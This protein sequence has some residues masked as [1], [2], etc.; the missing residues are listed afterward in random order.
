MKKYLARPSEL[1][2]QTSSI[3]ITLVG[4]LFL[5]IINRFILDIPA[6]PF[7]LLMLVAYATF[8]GGIKIGFISFGLALIY[9]LFYLSDN[10]W[11]LSYS[12][13]NLLR[14]VIFL[15][16]TPLLVLMLGLMRQ[17][18][19]RRTEALQESEMNYRLLFENSLDGIM[20][21]IPDGR[22][23]KANP[24]L[25]RML[26]YEEAEI[27]ALGR[28]GIVDMSDPRAA[29][30]LE[31]R[32]RTGSG[33]GKLN[34]L[35]KDGSKIPCLVTSQVFQDKNG[36]PRTSVV[37][38]DLRLYRKMEQAL[39]ESEKRY[40][41][42]AHH[43][44]DAAVLLFDHDLRYVLA[45]GQALGYDK[46]SVEGK[47]I[48][49]VLPS[50]RSEKLASFYRAALRGETVSTEWQ[51][52]SGQIYHVQFLPLR[53]EQGEITGGMVFSQDITR[54]KQMEQTLQESEERYRSIVTTLHEGIVIQNVDGEIVTCNASAE[55]ILGLNANQMMDRT[56]VD[57]RWRAVHEDG[58]PFPGEEHPAMV[59]LRTG[60]PCYDVV[61][62]MHKPEGALTWILV[63]SQ[64]IQLPGETK[65]S[66]VITSFADITQLKQAE[67]LLAAEKERLAVTLQSI[68]DAVI[69]TD[70]RGK[71]LFLNPVA[72]TLTGWTQVEAAGQPL[73]SI[74]RII[75]ET[76]RQP[77]DNPVKKV[78]DSGKIVTLAN[79]TALIS[80]DGL[81]YI[82]ADS[83]API[84]DKD[85]N[86]QGV[87]LVF[88][89]V[90]AEKK[91][92]EELSKANRLES[93][94]LLAG[95]IAHDFN[96]LL[97]AIVGSISLA[98]LNTEP[99]EIEASLAL[100][101]QASLQAKELTG[102]L[103]TFAKGGAPVKKLSRIEEI[104]REAATFALHGSRVRAEYDLAPQLWA[105]EVDAGQFGQVIQN[106]VINAVQAMPQGGTIHIKGENLTL[107]GSEALPLPPDRYIRL[108]IRDE[109]TGISPQNLATI[110]D[111]YFTTKSGG[112]GLGLATCY[113][114]IKHHNGHIA[115]E[116]KL[117]TGTT[118]Y[119]YLPASTTK[120][121]VTSKV[122]VPALQGAGR[123]LVMDDEPLIRRVLVKTLA[124]IGFEV[125]TVA[126]GLEALNCYRE[127]KEAGRAF[128]VVIMDLTIPGGMGGK[129]AVAY[130]L[131]YDPQAKVIVS[132]GYSSDAIASNYQKYGF[133]A[134]VTKPY[135]LEELTHT[136]NELINCQ[137][138]SR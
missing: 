130:L 23:L 107:P 133:R 82:I 65:P 84:R 68:G 121:E 49:E 97:T 85:G 52:P 87:V 90:T 35:H 100:A 36:H 59:T 75:D 29:P 53:N 71:T 28:T 63:N 39:H 123:V 129:E 54:R 34:Y 42:L 38:H 14:L 81:E 66:A 67:N 120:P 125:E 8:A 5:A 122:A 50:P 108:S 24:A 19:E 102:Q 127:A 119:I 45:E 20:L 37:A 47:T 55:R 77:L 33:Q 56:S 112:S 43:I 98:R 12:P 74:F 26:G 80:R 73:S 95:G 7:L 1:W 111:P 13:D 10:F 15:A 137:E 88:R 135:K 79:H 138:S 70:S 116:S 113:S 106:L 27:I 21:T 16:G 18:L 40:R 60:Q 64:P 126:E 114:I 58:S 25:C 2:L 132:S 109:G 124:L 136:I 46:E 104:I 103:L 93:V 86:I 69:T 30:F 41:D 105:V 118:F 92:A 6:Q 32:A 62:G 128:D 44:P 11:P 115:V 99:R 89:D 134:V 51:P 91:L 110:F 57:P 9:S 94:G 101:E 31:E 72:E 76:S 83:G 117:G 3:V 17:R 131:D 22:I 4:L 48:W 78:L 96:N 61:M